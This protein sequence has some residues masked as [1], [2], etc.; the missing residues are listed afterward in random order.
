MNKLNFSLIFF[1]AFELCYYLLIAQTGIVEF[2]GSD[3]N[4]IAYMP[5]GGMIGSVLSTYI[6]YDIK[7]KMLLLAF[8]QLCV[9]FFYPDFNSLMLFVL[10]LSVG[11]MAPL[12]IYSLRK[13]A[14]N[15]FIIIL[16]ISY[17]VGTSLFNT[18][19]Q[20]RALLG[21]I[22]SLVVL[23][24]IF[25]TGAKKQLDKEESLNYPVFMMML[26]VFL[27]SA[28]FESLSRDIQ[29]PIW[30]GGYTYEIIFF[31]ITGVA[32][33]IKLRLGHKSK[34]MIIVIMFALSYLF[35]FM[36]EPLLLSVVYPFVISYYNTV[37]LQEIIKIK[38]IRK[39]GIVMVF[40]GWIASGAGLYFALEDLMIYIPALFLL[41][42]IIRELLITK[43][44]NS[45]Q[46][47]YYV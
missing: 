32:A 44:T 9:T 38:E 37:I 17:L 20:D 14:P 47:V 1:V 46:G 6:V 35:Y 45:Q 36:R 25:K 15:D 33:A 16:S 23:V 10:G 11:G 29:I 21:I 27:D 24:S 41:F 19:V 31:H 12:I 5:L 2:F 3:L 18:P 26:W 42:I 13:A 43:K 34:E 8:I 28:L 7:K 40:I 22:F 39:T 30:R 4:V